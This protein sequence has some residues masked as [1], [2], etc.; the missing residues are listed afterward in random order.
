MSMLSRRQLRLVAMAV[1]SAI[2]S[3]TVESPGDW[4]TPPSKLPNIKLRA[5][6][7][8]KISIVRS[9]PEFT[10][11]VTLELLVTL[12]ADTAEGAQDAIEGLGQTIEDA[13]FSAQTIV[14]LVQQFP[15]VT[16]ETRITADGEQHVAQMRMSVECEVFETYD[17]TLINPG[18]YPSLAQI[19]LHADLQRP[20]DASGTY[21]GPAFPDSVTPAPRTV[22]PDGRDEGALL[23]DLPTS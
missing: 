10:T 23:I 20:F 8:R 16:T 6:S 1:I 7:E 14:Q 17:P 3:I 5:P 2:T 4:E 13:F 12:Q 22:G 11:T 21:P 19:Q 15:S 18:D 9:M